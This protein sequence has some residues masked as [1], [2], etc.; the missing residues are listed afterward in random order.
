[1]KSVGDYVNWSSV[2][3]KAFEN[4]LEGLIQQ[5]EVES[6]DQVVERLRKLNAERE[7][8]DSL[9]RGVEIGK[10]WAMN[11][12][13]PAQLDA[14]ESFRSEVSDAEWREMFENRRGLRE[15]ADRLSGHKSEERRGGARRFWGEILEER[16]GG[17]DF[18]AGFAEGALEV[19]KSVKDRI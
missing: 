10:R 14:I 8:S 12:A 6:L 13:T 18:F 15:L 19:W 5:E 3:C 11:R 7:E 1:M 2:A 9:K 4:K 17:T 16:P